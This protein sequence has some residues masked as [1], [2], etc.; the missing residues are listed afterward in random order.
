MKWTREVFSA[1]R[2]TSFS[3]GFTLIEL[4]I[5]MA[6]AA[7]LFTAVYAA[8]GSQ[9][10]CHLEQQQTV[11]MQQNIRAAFALMQRD[12]R[13]AGYDATWRDD[14]SDGRH[15]LRNADLIDNDCDG[16]LDAADPEGDED[17]DRAGFTA[18]YAHYLQLALDRGGDGD[19]CDSQDRIGFGFSTTRDRNRDGIADKGAAPL[20]RSVGA[21][22]LQPLAENLQAV[23]FGYA[24]DDDYGTPITDGAIDTNGRAVVWAYDRDLDGFLDTRLDSNADGRIDSAD[25]LDGNGRVDDAALTPAVPIRRI[26]AVQVWLLARTR[27]PL[28]NLSDTTT[29]VV[30]NKILRFGD[31]YKR[32]LLTTVVSCRN[33]GLRR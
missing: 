31:G 6:V 20:G 9:L 15:D 13:M 5:A 8:F 18:A 16:R 24:F 27:S 21:G 26:R 17:N 11:D 28:R 12:I 30:G 2:E 32:V 23:A 29:Y 22:G 33:L 19:F 25:D 1:H 7:L 4:M 14:N 3:G 10:R